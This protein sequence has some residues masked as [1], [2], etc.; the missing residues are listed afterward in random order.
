MYQL[1]YHSI[2]KPEL[3]CIDLDKIL[4]KAIHVNSKK[5]IT[6][7]LIYHNNNFVQILEGKKEDVL[8]VYKKIKADERHHAV[9]LL[10]ES[11]SNLRHFPD[12]NMA[13]HQPES[14]HI[15]S[16]VNNLTLLSELSDKATP[17]LL[18]F[19]G[20]VKKVLNDKNNK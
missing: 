18:S 19:W 6:G 16:F 14:E 2:S 15:I 1:N 17:T 20:T 12:W 11:S 4:E 8:S 9:T 10:W 13:Y 7:C 3:S 5:N